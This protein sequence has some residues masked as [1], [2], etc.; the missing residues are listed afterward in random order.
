M[1]EVEYNIDDS[2]SIIDSIDEVTIDEYAN[3]VLLSKP[4][5]KKLK[6]EV[7]N[8]EDFINKFN[9]Q[10]EKLKSNPH[11][12][13][14][15]NRNS[16]NL[17][18]NNNLYRKWADF[19]G[20]VDERLY[21]ILTDT[22][23]VIAF[24]VKLGDSYTIEEIRENAKEECHAKEVILKKSDY[25]LDMGDVAE[26]FVLRSITEPGAKRAFFGKGTD[27]N[28]RKNDGRNSIK[29]DVGDKYSNNLI[30]SKII[31]M[32]NSLLKDRKFMTLLA[33]GKS[34]EEIYNDYKKD[35]RKKV[36][37]V[38][39]NRNSKKTAADKD[40]TVSEEYINYLKNTKAELDSLYSSGG[41]FKS[42]Y[43][44]DIYTELNNI[45]SK[46]DSNHDNQKG[47]TIKES[48]LNKLLD[49]ASIYFN[50]RKGKYVKAPV[51]DRGKARL[52]LVE[53]LIVR[54]DKEAN[55][56]PEVNKNQG[57]MKL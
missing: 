35:V 43:M 57:G 14:F 2:F 4:A 36:D 24:S 26:Y 39:T 52:E 38:V 49:K 6:P 55:K 48:D 54:T 33:S 11:F 30:Q 25:I 47:Y 18:S 27:T 17:S 7:K 37:K 5:I 31:Q 22:T 40:I 32:R 12:I 50:N 15:Y 10:V 13:A 56:K 53:K 23:P 29:P 41:R 44:K 21:D 28:N 46:A 45:L 42:K 20:D 19:K 16:S 1:K 9:E 51:T 34:V 3:R 8:S